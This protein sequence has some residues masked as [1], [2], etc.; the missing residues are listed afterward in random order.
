MKEKIHALYEVLA[1]EARGPGFNLASTWKSGWGAHSYRH[2]VL[3]GGGGE[4]QTS[5]PEHRQVPHTHSSTHFHN[6]H[7]CTNTVKQF[8]YYLEKELP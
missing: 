2:R 1:G 6:T 8:N 7:L 5:E 3:K 4:R